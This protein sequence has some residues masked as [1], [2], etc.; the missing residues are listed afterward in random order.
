M[1]QLRLIGPVAVHRHGEPLHL[2]SRKALAL[3]G[4]RT[5]ATMALWR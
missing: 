3:D 2:G 5:R 4:P 1:S